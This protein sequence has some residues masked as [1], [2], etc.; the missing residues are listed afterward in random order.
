LVWRVEARAKN[1]LDRGDAGGAAELLRSAIAREVRRNPRHLNLLGVCEARM[2]HFDAA[3]K[4]FLSVLSDFPEDAAA[5]TNMGNLA[6]LEGDH[7]TARRYYTKAL[8]QNFLLR[9]PRFNL[10]R[11]YQYM[12]HFEKAMMAYQ[13]YLEIT[14]L[15]RLFHPALLLLLVIAG[16]VLLLRH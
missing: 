5:L 11:S 15:G 6:F 7:E 9:E 14:K 8:Q 4:L 3:R 1:M 12:G 16:L 10:I 2:G 13:D